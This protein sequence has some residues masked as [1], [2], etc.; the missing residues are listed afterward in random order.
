MNMLIWAGIFFLLAIIAGIFGFRKKAIKGS[1]IS[2][3]LFF[4]FFVLF[5]VALIFGLLQMYFHPEV[6]VNIRVPSLEDLPL[7]GK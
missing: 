7:P 5:I 2:K 6:D 4:I 3:I 1:Q